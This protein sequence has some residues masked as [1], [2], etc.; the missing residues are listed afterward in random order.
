MVNRVIGAGIFGVPAVLFA[1]IGT[2]SVAAMMI[3]AIVVLGIALCFA[4]VGSRFSGSGGPYLYALEAFGPAPG[5]VVGWLL[6][7]TQLGG[8]AAVANL[9]VNYLGW[10]EPAVT[11]GFPRAAIITAL[12]MVLTLVN[13]RGVRQAARLNN[14]LTIGKL[15]PLVLFVIVGAFFMD[16]TSFSLAPAPASLGALTAAV[17]VAV[18]PYSGFEVTVALG[19]EMKEPA[20]TIPLGLLTGM[21]LVTVVYVGVQVV[22]IGTL[23]GLA[24]STRPLADAGE[25]LFGRPGALVMVAGAMVSTL[26]VLHAIMLAA[27]R[28]PFAMAEQRQLP[29]FLG[30]IHPIHRTPAIGLI[31]SAAGML[32]FTLATTFVSALTVTVGLRVLIYLVTCAALPV[33]RRR[34]APA[35]FMVPGG[36]FLAVAC[37]V[38]AVILLAVR[39]WAETRQLAIAVLLGLAGWGITRLRI[40]SPFRGHNS[41]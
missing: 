26:G 17:L 37:I 14:I 33:L 38:V 16:R 6:W 35:S 24:T 27:G 29:P 9:L 2:M 10:F 12:V 4:E 19:G 23:P 18:Y 30:R 21:L 15:V 36:S 39:P 22:A 41:S 3:A 34:L 11:S 1:D 25:R 28:V 8:F 31:V 5:F 7:V 20:R 40:I 32:G 13:I